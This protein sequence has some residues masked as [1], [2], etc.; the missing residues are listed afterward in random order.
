MGNGYNR[1][2]HNYKNSCQIQQDNPKGRLILCRV[3]AMPQLRQ[4]FLVVH[5]IDIPYT[6]SLSLHASAPG[7]I[8]CQQILGLCKYEVIMNF[9]G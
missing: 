3:V 8:L 5:L 9:R 1:M 7:F 6:H 4:T 2:P